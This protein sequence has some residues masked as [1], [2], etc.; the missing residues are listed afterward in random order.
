M[1]YDTP[2]YFQRMPATKYDPST[3]NYG[4]VEP[5][6]TKKFAS[7]T[8]LGAKSQVIIFG[9][10]KRGSKVVRLQNEYSEPFDFIRIGDKKYEADFSREL[11]TKCSFI[12]SEV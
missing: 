6:E 3:G 2:V 12:V 11:R 9:K 4:N 7:V 10:I 8:S 5:V 1:R